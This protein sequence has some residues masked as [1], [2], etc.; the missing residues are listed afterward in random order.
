MSNSESGKKL[1]FGR[2]AG[3]FLRS[4]EDASSDKQT[5][6]A[7]GGIRIVS[8]VS[9]DS[10]K[11]KARVLIE[12]EA[13]S[14]SMEFSLL[15]EFVTELGLSIGD[16]D[17]DTASEI[18]RYAE[19]TR[20]YA[21]ACSSLAF[22][23]SSCRALERKL[24]QKGFDRDIAEGAI[25]V[26]LSRG[27]VD[28]NNIVES[29]IRIFLGKRWGKARIVAKLR[30]EG[31]C[32]SA[33]KHAVLCLSEVDFVELCKEHLGRKYSAIPSDCR[34]RE[35]MYASLARYGY[36]SSEIREAMQMLTDE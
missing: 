35:K 5:A 25:S 15:C 22:A 23:D 11:V 33:I 16:I 9:S 28:E 34:E 32:N 18:E 19:V 31:F 24:I 30:E 36:S 13:G 7:D 27:L 10:G 17:G 8:L 3:E 14:E 4:F 1:G 21:S 12:N 29:R 2:D 26:V 20:A 6:R